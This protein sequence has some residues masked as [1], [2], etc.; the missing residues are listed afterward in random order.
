MDVRS[1]ILE[2]IK[3]KDFVK[4]NPRI[5]ILAVEGEKITAKLFVD[6]NF[7][8]TDSNNL[9]DLILDLENEIHNFL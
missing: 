5:R 3:V 1:A 8:W 6:N 4:V 9:N 2:S 7:I